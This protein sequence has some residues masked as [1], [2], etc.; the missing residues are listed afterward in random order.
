MVQLAMCCTHKHEDV[1]SVHMCNPV[2]ASDGSENSDHRTPWLAGL[3]KLV[4][5]TSKRD[6]VSKN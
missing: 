2:S 6:L 1:S 4:S 3:P 5:F